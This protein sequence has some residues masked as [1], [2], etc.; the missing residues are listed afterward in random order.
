MGRV[1]GGRGSERC[2][3]VQRTRAEPLPA[4]FRTG[5]RRRRLDACAMAGDLLMKNAVDASAVAFW[6]KR[7]KDSIAVCPLS[8]NVSTFRGDSIRGWIARLADVGST[9]AR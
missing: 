7:D 8:D 1:Y 2:R 5:H 4:T 3:R 9:N 6:R